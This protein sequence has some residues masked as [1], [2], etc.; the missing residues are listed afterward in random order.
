MIDTDYW[1]ELA[2]EAEVAAQLGAAGV[3]LLRAVIDDPSSE[4]ATS[5]LGD[6]L[7]ERGHPWGELIALQ[8][9]DRDPKRQQQIIAKNR[10]DLL[11]PLA[12]LLEPGSEQFS[13]GLLVAG[14]AILEAK[15]TGSPLWGTVQELAR[16]GAL[17]ATTALRRL[18]RAS[19]VT[20]ADLV[21]VQQ[22]LALRSLHVELSTS[23]DL[24]DLP[25][26]LPVVD[27]LRITTSGN[28]NLATL[29]T[30]FAKLPRLH[31]L[32]FEVGGLATI[33]LGA[34]LQLPFELSIIVNGARGQT[35]RLVVDRAKLVV[36]NTRFESFPIAAVL[37]DVTPGQ[38]NRIVVTSAPSL[39]P[40]WALQRRA[41]E[42]AIRLEIAPIAERR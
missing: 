11:G 42:L 16:P 9:A 12:R 28:D 20:R 32:A 10:D 2:P 21:A 41:R 36:D 4:A 18:Q 14:R 31:E 22:P 35:V 29:V 13:R 17:L 33:A 7:L 39:E 34:L 27:A 19:I 23:H 15:A 8:L 24:S 3:A 30:P 38:L 37:A 25:R 6:Y 1:V 26:I 5:V 40:R